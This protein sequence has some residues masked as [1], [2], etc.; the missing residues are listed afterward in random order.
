MKDEILISKLKELIITER[1]IT[2]QI[3]LHLKEVESRKLHLEM[4]YASMFD[5]CTKELKY[6]SSAASRRISAMRIL[7]ALPEIKDRILDGSVNLSTL[8]QMQNFIRAEEKYSNEKF[9]VADKRELLQI[10]ENKTQREVEKELIKLSPVSAVPSSHERCISEDA[11]EIRIVVS[12]QFREKLG[13]MRRL[14][15]HRSIELVDVL[16]R[17]LDIAIEKL[18]PVHIRK[19]REAVSSK[20]NRTKVQKA[21]VLNADQDDAFEVME[22]DNTEENLRS[23]QTFLENSRGPPKP[24]RYIK[25]DIVRKIHD[26]ASGQCEYVS[27]KTG[28]RCNGTLF[29]EIDHIVPWARGGSNEFRNLQLLCGPHNKLKAEHEFPK[30][31]HLMN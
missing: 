1:K 17:A 31:V 10:I 21:A 19:A 2:N 27:A 22:I 14:N 24:S 3:L 16:E 26:R 8:N 15:S 28:K 12:S 18:D 4:G 20:P 23:Y 13:R 6:S 30:G 29:L 11:T 7:K 5:F 9:E 25:K